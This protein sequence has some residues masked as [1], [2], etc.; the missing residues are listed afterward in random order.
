MNRWSYIDGDVDVIEDL[1][2]F[3]D[4]FLSMVSDGKYIINKSQVMGGG[5]FGC[6]NCCS[7][8]AMK[9]LTYC[10]AISISMAVPLIYR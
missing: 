2:E 5:D 4:K 7:S 3:N 8:S 1:M 9:M 10:G 6:K